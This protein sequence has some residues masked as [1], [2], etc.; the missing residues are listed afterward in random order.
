MAVAEEASVSASDH[1]DS[2]HLQ[3]SNS[4]KKLIRDCKSRIDEG[5]KQ[6]ESSLEEF[7]FSGQSM[8]STITGGMN[9]LLDSVQGAQEEWTSSIQG[10]SSEIAGYITLITTT[11]HRN[12]T[13][14]TIL[15]LLFLY[16]KD[17]IRLIN[18]I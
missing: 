17:S 14:T 16:S 4:T 11:H 3:H 13:T 5:V 12:N 7:L 2:I 1:I 15:T 6:Q 8:H 18:R 9:D 10:L